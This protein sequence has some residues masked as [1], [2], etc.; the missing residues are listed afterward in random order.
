MRH[1]GTVRLKTPRLFLRPMNIDDCHAMFQS[2][3][4][5]PQIARW[6]LCQPHRDWATTA[7]SLYLW[8]QQA[9]DPTFYNWGICR[10]TDGM[11]LG[12][13]SCTPFENDGVWIPG[14]CLGQ[15]SGGRD[16]PPKHCKRY[17]VSG[18][19]K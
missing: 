1:L 9:G 6:L 13:I 4:E 10:K 11:L 15:L 14:Y 8:Q 12:S 17:A 18:L 2:W 3:A 5:D 19:M 7:E 16:M